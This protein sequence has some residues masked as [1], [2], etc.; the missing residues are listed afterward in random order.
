MA[1]G[2]ERN[3]TALAVVYTYGTQ[4]EIHALASAVAIATTR[5]RFL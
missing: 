1:M 2:P 3:R 5:S 4:I